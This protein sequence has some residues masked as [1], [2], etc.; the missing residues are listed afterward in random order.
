MKRSIELSDGEKS[1][2]AGGNKLYPRVNVDNIVN[3]AKVVED[4]EARAGSSLAAAPLELDVGTVPQEQTI[5]R[6][7]RLTANPKLLVKPEPSV[8]GSTSSSSLP[9]SS[10]VGAKTP[11]G[12]KP[13]GRPRTGAEPTQQEQRATKQAN[14]ARIQ[15]SR[16][17]KLTSSDAEHIE[18]AAKHRERKHREYVQRVHVRMFHDEMHKTAALMQSLSCVSEEAAAPE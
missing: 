3:I 8:T 17:A 2:H 10:S 4:A 16:Q 12:P 15:Q 14:N 7:S 5:R 6:F 18:W 11:Q 9:L 13:R 1:P